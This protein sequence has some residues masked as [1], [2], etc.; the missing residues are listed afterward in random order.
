MSYT[1][2]EAGLTT[3]KLQQIAELVKRA[4]EE[5]VQLRIVERFLSEV[6]RRLLKTS[7]VIFDIERVRT[8]L[9]ILKTINE[10]DDI[11][12]SL[13][14]EFRLDQEFHLW[15]KLIADRDR[16]IETY[17]FRRFCDST[18]QP[19]DDEIFIA[20]A[21]FYRSLDFSP[22]GQ[23][24]FDLAVTRLFSRA[25]ESDRR[26]L[27][28]T[29]SEMVAKLQDC[30]DRPGR[31]HRTSGDIEYAI[32]AI[33]GFTE[34]A[35]HLGNFED[36]VR[37]NIFDRYRIFK[38][39][40]GSLFFEAEIV[41]AAIECNVMVGNVFN[42]L[43]RAADEQLSERLTVDVDLPS[44]LHDASPE[45]RTH[46]NEL[47]RVFFG[48][49]EQTNVHAGEDVDYLGKLLSA[50]AGQP[51]GNQVESLPAQKNS[52]QS[53]LAP[54]LSTLTQAR[55]DADLLMKQIHRSENLKNVDVNDFLYHK[56]GSPDVLCRRALGLILWSLEFRETEL[57][58]KK[59]LTESIQREVTALLYKA[60]HLANSIQTEIEASDEHN[61]NRLRSVL[62]CLLD[63]RLRLE[64]AI[65]RFTNRKIA[66]SEE[67][68]PQT[69][70]ATPSTPTKKKGGFASIFFRWLIITLVLASVAGG[71][72]FYLNKQFDVVLTS[73]SG[74]GNV[75]VRT[76][77]QNE[78]MRSAYRHDHT[79]FINAHDT[80]K[81]RSAEERERSLNAILEDPKQARIQTVVVMGEEGDVVESKS[82][83][84]LISDYGNPEAFL[85]KMNQ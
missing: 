31:Q 18:P 58:Q 68:A 69:D 85:N 70:S 41:A 61:E 4:G 28:A 22:A 80:W 47:F 82:R 19:F 63:S 24:K 26:E 9:Q 1:T 13:E 14:A 52:V 2:T 20:L 17:H 84:A 16:N 74:F 3:E 5:A 33:D 30:F 40:L 36:L 55:P 45:A 29:R 46:I 54:F 35:K 51:E 27:R 77:P 53:R 34:E 44:V 71:I 7:P 21:S 12:E 75:D 79:L 6:E 59:E 72:L 39:E 81:K 65:V 56:D 57:Q 11:E 48:E 64:R 38:R 8:A 43:L 66:A 10:E 78:Y 60:E 23:S 50:S 62:N 49:S 67:A 42:G 83:S 15:R 76:L 73:A 37:S 32:S 25:G